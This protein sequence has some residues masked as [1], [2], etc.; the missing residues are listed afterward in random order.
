LMAILLVSAGVVAIGASYNFQL[1]AVENI[2]DFR[3]KIVLPRMLNYFIGI[4]SSALLP[5]AFAGFAARRAYWRA[6]A[7]LL[8]LL[9]LYPVTLSK[10]ALVT[11]FVLIGF[12]LLSKAFESRTVVVVSLLGP[13]MTGLVL[14]Y[15]F[16]AKADLYLA[17]VNHRIVAI[18][19]IALDV[20]TDFF[21]RH[22]FTHFCQLSFSKYFMS[23]PY[24]EPLSIVMEQT[25][26]LG[27]FNAS[28]FA[29][30]GIASVGVIFA[31]IA[32]FACGLL[33]ACANRLSAGLPAGFILVSGAIM[34]QILLNVPLS[35]AL[36][37]HGAI[38]LV[39][40]WY[41]TPRAMFRQ[42][43]AAESPVRGAYAAR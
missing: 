16:G 37:S 39:L 13:I 7:V 2:Y 40:L 17:F 12:L 28:L 19:A 18:P 10:V 25:Y 31:P 26:K 32:V 11:P 30:E 4:T 22:E 24:Q 43:A 35:T 9:C 21:S 42:Q 20:Y 27:N 8:L 36:L 6:G 34:P 3:D 41:V 23:C 15:L 29:T 33:I 5:F 38:V 14:V 1:V